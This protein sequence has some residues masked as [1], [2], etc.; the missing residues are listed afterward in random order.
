MPWHIFLR[1]ES[2]F[3]KESIQISWYVSFRVFKQ[4]DY[5]YLLN[6]II[7]F[8]RNHVVYVARPN[9]CS[10]KSFDLQCKAIHAKPSCIHAIWKDFWWYSLWSMPYNLK[11]LDNDICRTLLSR[12]IFKSPFRSPVC[13]MVCLPAYFLTVL[14]HTV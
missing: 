5:T 12:T 3:K 1:F 9:T 2:I 6:A 4:L 10:C 14:R 11:E 8:H 7:H 13:M